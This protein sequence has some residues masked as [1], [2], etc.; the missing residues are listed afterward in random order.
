MLSLF[1]FS[2]LVENYFAHLFL[3]SGDGSL[4]Y[5]FY[6]LI[7]TY[8]WVSLSAL[9]WLYP[10]N[11]CVIFSFLFCFFSGSTS[12]WTQVLLLEPFCQPGCNIF[13]FNSM[14]FV[15]IFLETSFLTYSL[16][17]SVLFSS[18]TP[19]DFLV[20]FLLLISSAV[21]CGGGMHFVWFKFF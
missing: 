20:F 21:H 7:Y 1:S 11:W 15:S 10:Q 2:C 9:L 6:L 13:L 14:H 18:Q 8:T 3:S 19:E 16:Y 5:W 12:V 17:I 4:E